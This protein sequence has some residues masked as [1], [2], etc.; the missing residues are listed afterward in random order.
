MRRTCLFIYASLVS[1]YRQNQRSVKA[2][3]TVWPVLILRSSFLPLHLRPRPLL[4]PPVWEKPHAH[5]DSHD[6]PAAGGGRPMACQ[7]ESSAEGGERVPAA[8]E[9][10]G[11]W[12]D[13][14]TSGTTERDTQVGMKG[15]SRLKNTHKTLI[16]CYHTALL[17]RTLEMLSRVSGSAHTGTMWVSETYLNPWGRRLLSSPLKLFLGTITPLH[18]LPALSGTPSPSST[19]PQTG[20][21]PTSILSQATPDQKLWKRTSGPLPCGVA[22]S[23]SLG[24]TWRI[25]RNPRG[26]S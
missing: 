11:C 13:R 6:A 10:P 9:A 12:S 20:L 16:V 22:A 25:W 1:Q 26:P 14:R 4:K 24:N 21:C 18:P 7:T 8:G 2:H 23:R 15:N 3:A 19:R 17:W 5:G